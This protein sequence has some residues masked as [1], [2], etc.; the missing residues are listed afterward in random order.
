M[1]VLLVD[2]TWAEAK[3]ACLSCCPIRQPP[4]GQWQISPAGALLKQLLMGSRAPDRW[5]G[6]PGI[7]PVQDV[8]Q[9]LLPIFL[10][11][12]KPVIPPRISGKN[13]LQTTS[14]APCKWPCI[15]LHAW[16]G[17]ILSGCCCA[18]SCCVGVSCTCSQRTLLHGHKGLVPH[19]CTQYA[20][21]SRPL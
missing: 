5:G 2:S 14:P 18:T 10:F 17:P 12:K 9:L 16:R 21:L 6:I 11:C 1:K 15:N 19:E 8:C 3:L 4:I 13:Q 20:T 7:E